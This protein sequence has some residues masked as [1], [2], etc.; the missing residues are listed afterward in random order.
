MATGVLGQEEEIAASQVA[1]ALLATESAI[2]QA[3]YSVTAASF[4]AYVQSF[5]AAAAIRKQELL[6]ELTFLKQVQQS[7]FPQAP[8]TKAAYTVAKKLLES[9]L[10]GVDT[11]MND[12]LE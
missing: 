7:T 3:G 5:S 11:P 2:L 8:A 4:N 6:Q 9:Y 10:S 12:L 1:A